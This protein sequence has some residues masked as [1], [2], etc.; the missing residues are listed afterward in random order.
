M[1][2]TSISVSMFST[3]ANSPQVSV[4]ET[5]AAPGSIIDVN[6][7]ISN[8]PGILAAALKITYDEGLELLGANSGE[9]FK[10]LSM[11]SPE[12]FTSPCTFAW[13]AL[14]ITPEDIQD[15]TIVTL[16]FKVSSTVTSN[17]KLG[18]NVSYSPKDIIG[19]DLQQIP[20]TIKNSSV[21][22]IDYIPGDLNRD[23]MV[24]MK[25][26]ILIR[27]YIT[28]YNIKINELAADVNGDGNISMLDVIFMRRFIVDASGFN[29]KLV[30]GGSKVHKHDMKKINA[31][32]ATCTE[33]GNIEYWYCQSC[34]K[35][36][37]DSLGNHEITK[38]QTV[39]PAKGHTV[40]IDPAVEATEEHEGL[41]EGSHCSVCNK[42]IVE[43][44][45]IPKLVK[46]TYPVIYHISN[47]DPYLSKLNIANNNPSTYASEE[48]LRLQNLDVP[49]YKFL[50]WYDL[51]SGPSATNM[52]EIP[53]GTTGRIDLYAMWI[54]EE[55][56][57]LFDSELVPVPNDV[58]HVNEDKPLP[59]P[60]L[61]GYIFT[62]WSDSEGNI[63]K[64]IPVGNIG[65]K[66]F[67]ANWTSER[68]KAWTNKVMDDPIIYED[69]DNNTIL[70]TYNIGKIEN[71]PVAVLKDFGYINSSGVTKTETLTYTESVQESVVNT[72]S[73]SVQNSTTD[74]CSWTMGKE[75]SQEIS[76]NEEW[77]KEEGK[78]L[79]QIETIGKDQ[80]G[81]W[82]AS[83]GQSGSKTTSEY[84]STNEHS[85]HTNTKNKK[86]HNKDEKFTDGTIAAHLDAKNTTT[87]AAKAPVKGI[88]LSAENKTELGSGISGSYNVK[89]DHLED[90][91]TDNTKY[92]E[93]G[94]STHGEKA[95]S[96]TSSFTS[97]SGYSV[98]NSV[99]QSNT[100]SNAFSQRISEKYGIG[101]SYLNNENQSET[102]GTSSSTSENSTS[103]S[104]L[105]WSKITGREQTEQF[106]TSNTKT[107]YHRW[108][109]AGTA[110]V[111]G[112]V[113]YDIAT[114]TYFVS[115]FSVLDDKY[116]TFE[117][118]SYSTS[119]YDDNQNSIIP[120]E[121]PGDIVKY[122]ANRVAK[123]EGL[124]ISKQGIVTGYNGTDDYVI[125][126][127]YAVFNNN[128]TTHTVVK[129]QG[130]SDSSVFSGK[131]IT[132][133]E[134]SD[135]ITAIP[136]NCFQ[137]CTNLK[138]INA[139][140]I[141]SIGKG[142]FAGC[143]S[144]EELAVGK[145]VNT[146][147]EGIVS[148]STSLVV[149]TNDAKVVGA[150]VASGAKDIV[151]SV[152]DNCIKFENMELKIPNTVDRFV[153]NGY[154]KTFNNIR[155]VSD[156]KNTIINRIN[157]KSDTNVPLV[158][159]SPNIQLRETNISAP[160][161]CL[162]SSSDSANIGLKGEFRLH[163]ASQKAVLSKN[164]EFYQIDP[165][166]TTTMTIGNNLLLFGN[167]LSGENLL[168]VVGRIINV[169]KNEYDNYSKGVFKINFDTNGGALNPGDSSAKDVTYGANIGN[170][171]V[172]HKDY[173]I[174]D[175]WYTDPVSG[176]K[177]NAETVYNY[178]EDITVYAHWT[179]KATSGW[180]KASQMPSNAKRVDTKYT[181]TQRLYKT[182]ASASMN[183]WTKY[184][185][186][187]TSWGATQ[188]P[189][190]SDP[191]N[192][193]RN[194]WSEQYVASQT[195]RY[196][197]Y[198]RCSGNGKWGS[199]STA[200]SW[201][202]HEIDLTYPLT[203]RANGSYGIQWYQSYA[204]PH[205][206]AENMWIPDGTYVVDNYATRWYYQ[207]PV[208]TYYFYRDEN[209][210][211][212]SNPTGK[213]ISNVQEWVRYI[214]A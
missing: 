154:G 51:P 42:I 34:N 80:T 59:T 5:I 186:K 202:R 184:D 179:Q 91:K 49:G 1:I 60:K 198:H 143:T 138:T 209:K 170:L 161:L 10:A 119:S 131:N 136:K 175:G 195:T 4:E 81:S 130:I 213:D 109:L 85:L 185:T 35:Y 196:K 200:K 95:A 150:A 2:F 83:S 6:I 174:F 156:A 133:I 96:T 132:G 97:E 106:T 69:P 151:I 93:Y 13:D 176:S 123:T 102:K 15:G 21:T 98:S 39:I 167:I 37:S 79:E 116:H 137:N 197:Y 118:Y 214:P 148:N 20:L 30:P 199:D 67:S 64:R 72:Y 134:L 201:A 144:L 113:G 100:V 44:K 41:T 145:E 36:F 125:I 124:V 153:I 111:F 110:Y 147:G 190:Y 53:V 141:T 61:D 182:S 57:I 159:S 24:D 164:V 55:Y 89:T 68:N 105:T 180:V 75:F 8:N 82:Y 107:G 128:D 168:N 29:V 115:T 77:Q 126:P 207:E 177:I 48:G 17:T 74:S 33:A 187:R 7:N 9:A 162:I 210:E 58:Y 62:G 108:I 92:D 70:F 18:V 188:G 155:I 139:K 114:N 103:G 173:C 183:G 171:P 166:L 142:A 47:G 71:V 94:K 32:E 181:Y 76:V 27:R 165:S 88:E 204:C 43:Q 87:I 101:K 52:K 163:S 121:A 84:A 169:S 140:G 56:T 31:L 26:V 73:K 14:E 117:D 206:G 45:V 28:G 65:T 86:N 22:I 25:D 46:N 40:V 212:T 54:P 203:F 122:V 16:K 157:I 158:F 192:G 11:T 78:T 194:V 211:S 178:S 19:A 112:V 135:Y 172:P 149:K 127:E 129:V 104:S 23:S 66:T 90:V 205:C 3:A 99:H 189:V 63:I 38:E 146:L 120:F 12:S 208:Y 50:G 191:N 193:S 152:L 160:G